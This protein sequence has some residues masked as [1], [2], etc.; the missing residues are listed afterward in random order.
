MGNVLCQMNSNRVYWTKSDCVKLIE[1][2]QIDAHHGSLWWCMRVNWKCKRKSPAKQTVFYKQRVIVHFREA[3]WPWFWEHR[4]P[5]WK[6]QQE[7]SFTP[8]MT[9]RLVMLTPFFPHSFPHFHTKT[10][11]IMTHCEHLKPVVT[12]ETIVLLCLIQYKSLQ[13]DAPIQGQVS[14]VVDIFPLNHLIFD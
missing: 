1:S 5:L 3:L 10:H 8:I 13:F 9:D 14:D 7:V 11:I 4:G 12:I 6:L 2:S